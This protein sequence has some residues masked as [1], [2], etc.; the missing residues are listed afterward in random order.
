MMR[1]KVEYVHPSTPVA[2]LYTAEGEVL[3]G[4]YSCGVVVMSVVKLEACQCV[5]VCPW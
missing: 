1:V 4:R 3:V 2:I 5:S